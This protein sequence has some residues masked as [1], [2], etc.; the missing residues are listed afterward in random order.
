VLH[1]SPKGEISVTMQYVK[2][3]MKKFP[4]HAWTVEQI[5]VNPSRIENSRGVF[6]GIIDSVR[7]ADIVLWSFPVYHL[8]VPAQM[9]RFIELVHERGAAKAFRGKYAAALMTSIHYYDH[10]ARN[11]IHAVSEDLGMK[12]SGAFTPKMD[13][14]SLK[15]VQR[16]FLDFF[17]QLISECAEKSA[18]PVSYPAAEMK[19]FTYKFA[20]AKAKINPENLKIRIVY[21]G[22]SANAKAMAGRVGSLFDSAVSADLSE[23]DIKGGCLGCLQCGLRGECA[24]DGKDGYKEF[25]KS[26]ILDA[27][28]IFFAGE[29]RDRYLSSRFKMFFD[30]S[31]YRNHMPAYEGKQI[32]WIISGPLSGNPNL[33]QILETYPETSHGN[34]AGFVSDESRNQKNIDAQID[35][36]ASRAVSLALKKYVP[37][38][39]FLG[40]A[41]RRLFREEVW[42][43]LGVVFAQDHAYYR[44]NGM[45]DFPW[46]KLSNWT[47]VPFASM[48]L[49]IPAVRR[50]FN[51][52]LKKGMIQGLERIVASA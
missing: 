38:E 16:S 3:L 21:D 17:S 48:I 4:E 37:A 43:H 12:F 28:V 11:Y 31:F 45:F 10:T 18:L 26:M 40:N 19:P 9:K 30:R 15:D 8:L 20:K 39:T 49:R 2:F 42:G 47:I 14:L 51:K 34:S 46:K 13:D 44:K 6:G 25:H 1:G 52:R 32:A 41:G 22:S 29:M 36:L 5:G 27:D 35:A 7:K 24:Y 50:G 23:L 33:R